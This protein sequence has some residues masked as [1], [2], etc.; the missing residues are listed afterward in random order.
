MRV[1]PLV[2]ALIAT[3]ACGGKP[4]KSICDNTVPPPAACQTQCDANPASPNTC[5]SGYHCA[6]DGFCDA[7]CTPGGGECGDGYTCTSDGRCKGDGECDGLECNVED[8]QSMGMPDT[9]IKGTVYAPNGTL[10]LYGITV[11][12]PNAPVGALPDGAQCSRCNEDLPGNP[13]VRATTD[14]NGQFT[15]TGAPAGQNI[16]LIITSGKWRRQITI[17]SVGKCMDNTLG[18]AETRLP[19]NR[20]EGDIPRI[21]LSTGGADSLECLLRRMGIDDSE[22]GKDGGDQRIHLYTDKDSNGEGVDQFK[23]GFAGG[24]GGF[25]DSQTL[26]SSDTKMKT[27]D[28]V[29]LSCEGG[30]HE[31]TKTKAHMDAMKAYADFG[32]RVFMS[33]WH[34]IWISGGY[35]NGGGPT[36]DVWNTIAQWQDNADT[37][38]G[39]VDA[40][41]ENNNSKGTA[42]ANWMKNVEPTSTRGE[43]E[44]QNG[45]GKSTATMLDMAKAERWTFIKAAPNNTSEVGHPQNFQFTTPNEAAA[46]QR[47]G[48]VVFSDMHVSGNGGNPGEFYPD[49]CG[50]AGT[51][52]AMTPQE[53]ALA[54]MLF[55]LAS[56]VGVIL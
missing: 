8:C 3:A 56:C 25:A 51:P 47:C 40:I 33:H 21:A 15:I 42:F 38:N 31:N 43:I 2:V 44:I 37:G 22:I 46:D 41:D 55:D 18:A 39:T 11:Y 10:P 9:T 45:T 19:K 49:T 17:P 24:T 34:N 28:I 4:G 32:G 26:W 29:I 27:Y 1:A 53:K 30:Q 13:L 6:P 16:P 54:F 20:T 7:L 48:K 14:E 50:D 35:E 36:P 23:S 52:R 12:V 5:P